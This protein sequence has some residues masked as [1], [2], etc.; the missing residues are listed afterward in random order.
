[1]Y[2]MNTL[3]E[4]LPLF[5][6]GLNLILALLVLRQRPHSRLHQIFALFLL[7]MGLWASNT[8]NMRLSPTLTAALSW[9][10]ATFAILP[11]A[12][13]FF[14]HFV[15]LFT[16]TRGRARQLPLAY[17]SIIIFASLAPTNLLV[18]GMRETW[19]GHGFV[20][21][22]LLPLYMSIFYGFV[23]IALI[24]LVKAYR[25]SVSTLE[26]NRY[27]YVAIGASLTLLGLLIDV[28]AVSGVHIYSMGI[29]SNIIFSALCTYAILKYQL[30]DIRV[31][32]RKGTAY[33]LVSVLGLAIYIGLLI[34]TYNFMARAGGLPVWLH[35]LFILINI[36]PRYLYPS[37]T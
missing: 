11:F 5:A 29:P 33:V 19:Y 31:V 30:L 25:T 6:F 22:P 37:G 32:V 21:G 14:Y 27:L 4:I 13:V 16:R 2:T 8:F 36:P 17:L 3:W 15:L 7:S 1:M 24:L 28:L 35:A 20:P 10:K 9:E 23:I 12:A 18:A 34:T 26:K